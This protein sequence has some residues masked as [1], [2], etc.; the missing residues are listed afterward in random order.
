MC[1]SDRQAAFPVLGSRCGSWGWCKP[2]LGPCEFPDIRIIGLKAV[3]L[4]VLA[5]SQ[6]VSDIQALS[7]NQNCMQFSF[8]EGSVQLKPNLKF[9]AG[10]LRVPVLPAKLT[11]LPSS[12]MRVVGSTVSA[13]SERYGSACWR[14]GFLGLQIIYLS[15]IGRV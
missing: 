11:L 2:P 5:T 14:L 1:H 15:P 9:M 7:V 8:D 13:L 10:K 4:V 6:R 3:L 12:W